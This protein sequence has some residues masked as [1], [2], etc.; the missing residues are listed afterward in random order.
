VHVLTKVFIVLVS[1]LAVLLVPL[2][3]VYAHNENSFK[4]RYQASEL[5]K[6]N[7]LEEMKSAQARAAADSTQKQAEI[8]QLSAANH[9][10]ESARAA[11]QAKIRELQANLAA[12]EGLKTEILA[13]LASVATTSKAS[14]DL[15]ESLITE[16]RQLRADTV[17]IER[18]RVQ[19][20]EALS[21]MKGQLEVAE[22]ARRALAEELT[23]L[24]GEHSAA[25]AKLSAYVAKYGSDKLDVRAGAMAG[26][27]PD[28]TLTATVI[29]VER[30]TGQV[31]AEI[32][33]GSRDGVKKDWAMLISGRDGF[34]ANLRI[35]DVDINRS[36][37]IVSME[38]KSRGLV[39]VNQ[40]AHA[41]AGHQ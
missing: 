32:N 27:T 41:Y 17:A 3:V 15:T 19:L 14:Q 33:A 24:K 6:A 37:G 22:A 28:R 26:I 18:Q 10:L 35:I 31:L 29:R 1:L 23:R 9:E 25:I 36:T 5:A 11:D 20:D 16:L 12:A 4:A 39:E 13:Q 21:E 8:S 34:V 7:A 38:E 40:T 2:V 30:S